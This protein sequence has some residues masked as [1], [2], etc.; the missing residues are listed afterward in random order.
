MP[1]TTTPGLYHLSEAATILGVAESHLR[2]AI[3]HHIV[4]PIP[5]FN[6]AFNTITHRFTPNHIAELRLVLEENNGLGFIPVIETKKNVHRNKSPE[7]ITRQKA[8]H[9]HERKQEAR[10]FAFLNTDPWDL[11]P[12]SETDTEN[13][14]LC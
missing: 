2:T 14:P 1:P 12:T 6:A 7:D 5:I 11:L 9:H 10:A 3:L 4:E 8:L 13:P